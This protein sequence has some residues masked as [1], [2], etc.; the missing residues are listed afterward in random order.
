MNIEIQIGNKIK[1]IRLR[2][3]LSIKEVHQISGLSSSLIS[4]VERGI[5][6]PTLNS[7]VKI[8]KGLGIHVSYFFINNS[9]SPNPVY[10]ANNHK[11]IIL[12]NS[13]IIYELLSPDMLHKVQL[14]L[15]EVNG[16]SKGKLSMIS[17]DGEEC[18]YIIKGQ[19]KIIL[20]K[21]QYYLKEGDTI[22]FDCTI[23]HCFINEKEEKS[24]SV[25]TIIPN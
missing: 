24:V 15:L 16:K 13:H 3:G 6:N 12:S 2:K 18:G 5:I 22:Y 10:R 20:G 1:E 21:K 7:L 9:K 8:S 11:K 19:L 14:L 17:H 4:K 25:W 23:P